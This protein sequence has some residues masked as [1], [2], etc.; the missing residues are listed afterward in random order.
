MEEMRPAKSETEVLSSHC[1]RGVLNS[2]YG[3]GVTLNFEQITSWTDALEISLHCNHL[4][5]FKLNCNCTSELFPMLLSV[6]PSL[7]FC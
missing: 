1:L 2:V 5:F 3:N 4:P 6:S 7:I